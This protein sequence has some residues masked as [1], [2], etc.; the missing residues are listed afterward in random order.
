MT[1]TIQQT[2]DCMTAVLEGELDHHCAGSI[3]KEIDAAVRDQEPV[4][5]YLDFHLV[6]FMDSSGIG[7]IM[8]RHQLMQSLGGQVLILDPPQHIRR[9]LRISGIERIAKVVS[10]KYKMPFNLFFPEFQKMSIRQE[11]LY[12]HF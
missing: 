11:R 6:T 3:R 2:D 12:L 10:S 5:L 4:L 1:V 8:G 7:L 9:V